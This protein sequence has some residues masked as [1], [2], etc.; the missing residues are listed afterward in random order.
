VAV[1]ASRGNKM[2]GSSTTRVLSRLF[3]VITGVVIIAVLYL[4]KIVFLPLAFAILFAFLLAPLVTLLERIQLPRILAILIV[5]LGFGLISSSI[6]W[7]VVMQL[8][9]VADELPTYRAN[10]EEKMEAIHS[11]DNSAFSRAR[12][13]VER[14]NEQ[15]GLANSSA[16]PDLKH[17]DKKVLGSSPDR[18]IQVQEVARPDGRLDQLGGI[19]EPLVTAFLSVVFT[20]FVLLEREDLRN[21][22]IRL[23]GDSHLHLTTQAMNDASR[24]ISR[25]FSLQFLVN[26]VFGLITFAA[27]HF[28]GLPHAFLF[29]AMATLLR[30][31]PYIGAPIAAFLPTVYSL[32][33]FHGWTT[34]LYILG[35]F[36]LLEGFTG[37]F[38]EPRLY[39]KHTGLSSLAILI[40]A[41]FWTLVW[42][43]VGLVLS[44]PLTVCLVVVGR[45]VP[46]LEFLTVLLG[47][48]PPIRPSARFYQRLLARDE[49][50]AEAILNSCLKEKGLAQLYDSV[51]IPALNMAEEDRSLNNL[52]SST[53][54][55]I[56]HTT[57]ALIEELGQRDAAGHADQKFEPALATDSG[58]RH[59]ALVLCV[60]VQGE[61]D[62][63]G[64]L[65]LAQ[66][67]ENAG[68][69]AT[70]APARRPEDMLA[71]C[72]AQ[73][74]DVIFVS[75][76][77]PFALAHSRRLYRGLRARHPEV[78]I[79]IGLWNYTEDETKAAQDIS[80]G[81]GNHVSTT[82]A[83]AV[84]EVQSLLGLAP[85][86]SSVVGAE[87][88]ALFPIP[89]ES[90]A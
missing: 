87:L 6:G 74:P 32:A 64:A 43:P 26:A 19:L 4:A 15:I 45:H 56:Y 52:E 37:N 58:H 21:R 85:Q 69:Q 72:A 50:E 68:M 60:P 51:V 70:A 14:L 83:H 73:K 16:V 67:L 90:A 8:V 20:F 18:P 88:P 76:M 78:K 44:V 79:I 36:V 31:I 24:R 49:R 55:F 89:G 42:G 81:E 25:Y 82:L 57:R 77:P 17:A 65:M 34:S 1:V 41:A 75:G 22:V 11:P 80:R 63:L 13:E 59:S 86:T 54:R 29:G 3:I 5:I 71:L 7:V 9:D 66:V 46:Y 40:A 27:L 47:D 33:M 23:T 2:I 62:E 35:T 28:L 12:R 48:Q 30:F 84:E 10:V 53:V 38:A 61:A 39:G